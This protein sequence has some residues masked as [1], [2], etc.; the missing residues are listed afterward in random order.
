MSGWQRS[1]LLAL[2]L[3]GALMSAVATA[4]N[5]PQPAN[6]MQAKTQAKT[7]GSAQAKAKAQSKHKAAK[8]APPH[9]IDSRSELRSQASQMAAGLQAAEAA[10]G[11]DELAIAEQ[12]HTGT[13]PCE[14]GA[15]V[16]LREDPQAPGYFDLRG[17]NFKFRMLPVVSQTGA[18]RLED[19]EA[20]AVWLQLANKS[21]LM[22]QKAG[23]RMADD[24]MSPAQ[25]LQAQALK[26][27]PPP[28]FLDAS[29]R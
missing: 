24:C 7:Q 26:A 8:K 4:Q 12:V 3:T 20:G 5:L 1:G 16:T 23:R 28:S 9:A 2:A 22:N 25:E 15:S 17:R 10:L 6:K 11:P 21:M 14:L 18:V 13:L 29:A 19:R 27:S